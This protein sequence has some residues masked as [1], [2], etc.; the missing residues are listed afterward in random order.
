[1]ISLS[2]IFSWDKIGKV[3]I[4]AVDCAVCNQSQYETVGHVWHVVA[5]LLAHNFQVTVLD[6][7][8]VLDFIR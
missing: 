2:L 4:Q 3:N 6:T 7:E 8:Y 5:C 1:M